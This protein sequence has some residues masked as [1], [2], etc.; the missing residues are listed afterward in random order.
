MPDRYGWLIPSFDIGFLWFARGAL[1][2]VDDRPDVVECLHGLVL[3]Q[4]EPLVLLEFT[5]LCTFLAGDLQAWFVEAKGVDGFDALFEWRTHLVVLADL[6]GLR[7]AFG[8]SVHDLFRRYT[9]G[10]FGN[11]LLE[12]CQLGILISDE[13]VSMM[14]W[15]LVYVNC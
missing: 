11:S 8:V 15:K 14:I 13:H 1:L 10:S 4:I 5:V 7:D 9:V 3:F 6:S 12:C 2:A